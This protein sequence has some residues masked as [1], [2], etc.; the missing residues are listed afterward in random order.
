MGRELE[1][2]EV[3]ESSA[4]GGIH[5]LSEEICEVDEQEIK[6]VRNHRNDKSRGELKRTELTHC[7]C[8]VYKNYLFQEVWWRSIEDGV[9]GTQESAPGLVVETEDD[10]GWLVLLGIT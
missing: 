2:K 4:N 3:G 7:R 8:I 10:G 1:K 9:D 5:S 6:K